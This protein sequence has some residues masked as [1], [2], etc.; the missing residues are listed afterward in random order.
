MSANINQRVAAALGIE[1]KGRMIRA[2][3]L[4][5]EVGTLPVLTIHELL[6]NGDQLPPQRFKWSEDNFDLDAACDAALARVNAFVE[7]R[8]AEIVHSMLR[9]A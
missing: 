5:V 9:R 2:F 6:R 1:L 7:Q 3:D 8:S 4:H